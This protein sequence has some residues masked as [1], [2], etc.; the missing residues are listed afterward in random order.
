MLTELSIHNFAII[1]E[2]TLEFLPAFN[3]L[4]GE[5]GAGKSIILDAVLLILGGRADKSMIRAECN[6]AIIEAVF[7]LSPA[8][9]EVIVPLLE[10][11]GVEDPFELELSV[12]REV[13]ENGRTVCRIN[14]QI[15]NTKL[16]QEIGSLLVDVHGQGSHLALLQA[17]SHLPLLDRYANVQSLRHL[18]EQEVGALRRLQAELNGLWQDEQAIADKV[19]RLTDWVKEIDEAHLEIGEDNDLLIERKRLGNIGQLLRFSAELHNA[20]SGLDNDTPSAIDLVSQ[21]QHSLSQLVRL[22]ESQQ[23]LL[24]QLENLLFQLK[25]IAAEASDYQDSLDFAPERMQEVEERLELIG[26]FKRRY[27]VDSIV[28]ILAL[29]DEMAAELDH[30]EHSEERIAELSADIERRLHTIGRM[31][32]ELSTKRQIAARKLESKIET[33]LHDLSMKARFQVDFQCKEDSNGIYVGEDRLAFDATGYDQVEFLLSSNPGEPLKPLAKVASGGETARIMLALKSALAQVDETPTLIFD[34]IDQGIGGRIGDI[35]GRKLWN[36][37]AQGND[38][39]VIIVTHL[40]QLAA[41]GDLHYHVRKQVVNGRTMT[42]VT[43][44]DEEER[45]IELAS[46]IGTD[47]VFARGAASTILQAAQQSKI[48]IG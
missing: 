2:L 27:K 8:Q 48:P 10:A 26:R 18:V 4:T 14:G 46:M 43:Q 33:E 16:L 23:P 12:L 32:H 19:E 45:L 41:Y 6:K 42:H 24:E 20:L 13:R 11:E 22:D 1:E 35:V 34:E 7:R 37:T 25:D 5:T 9:K 15:V 29:R 31:S 38:H 28:Q 40:P 17:K 36:L 39:Q 44:L 3:V 21:A 30:F 47:D